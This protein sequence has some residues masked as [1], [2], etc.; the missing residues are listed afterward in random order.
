MH[1][2]SRRGFL[3]RALDAGW[4]GASLMEKAVLRAAQARAQAPAA[5]PRPFDIDKVAD[6]V[7]AA[8]ARPAGQINCNAAIFENAKDVLIVDTHSKPSAAASMA[9][10]IRQEITR[11]PVRYIVN[12]HFHW[13]HIQGAPAYRRI[14]PGA[15]VLSSTTTRDLIVELSA[16]RLKQSLDEAAKS[17]DDWREQLAKARSAED[18]A[19]Y[20]KLV[21]ETRA[22][23]GEM[24]GWTPDVPSITFRQD[25]ILHDRAHDLHLAFRG[26]GHTAGDVVVFCPQK[27]VVAA[28]DL[29]HG[30]FPF[31]ADGYPR[32]WPGTLRTVAE[33][34]FESVIGGHG[35]V[36]RTRERLA[37]M[38]AYIDE[39]TNA[40]A[41]RKAAGRSLPRIQAEVTPASL[42]SLAGGYG[43]FVAGQS[44]RYYAQLQRSSPAEVLADGVRGNIADTFKALERS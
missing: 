25:L 26:R 17:L 28:G 36:Q 39:L 38:A 18:K 19:Y 34:D 13:D 22:Y 15:E 33:F 8:V 20:E 3:A 32:E 41:Q 27:R 7:Y 29:L 44:I 31:V 35:A 14:A 30:F 5:G 11:K 42:R 16:A 4:L 2:H 24:R 37:Q 12:T 43:D 21:S 6:G 10:Q 23:I 1:A 40:V 9:A